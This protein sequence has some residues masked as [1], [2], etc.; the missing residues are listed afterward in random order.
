MQLEVLSEQDLA[1]AVATPASR[2]WRSVFSFPVVMGALLVVLMAFTVRSRF[3]DPDLWWHLKT[4]EIIWN[5]HSIPRVDLF[6]FTAQG[7]PWIAQEWLSQLTIYG[8][9]RLGGY[10]GLMLWLVLLSSL[11]MIGA[12]ALG[13]LY[14][15]SCKL[16]FVAGMV[17]W[18]FSTVGLAIRPHMIGY[19]LLICE[20]L[21]VYLGRWRDRRWFL[22]LPPLFALWINCH[23]SFMFGLVVL[24]IVL[25]CSYFDFGLGL[26][27]G[28][29]WRKEERNM[30][31]AAFALSVAALFVNPIGPKL[32]WYPFDVM[33][34]QPLNVRTISE[35]QQ[36]SFESGRGLA[37]LAIA[38]L[39]LLVPLL[40]RSPLILQELMLAAVGFGFAVRHERMTFVFG[41]LVA[42]ILC[43]LLAGNWDR[44]R[45]EQDS[46]LPNASIVILAFPNS[47]MLAQ[48]VEKANPVEAVNFIKRSGL[49]GRMLN[50]YVYGGY[51]IWAMPEKRVFIDGRADV[52]E[53]AGVLTE[54]TNWDSLHID[55][56][57]FLNKYNIN[58]CLL[59]RQ[60]GLTH[61]LPLLAG[62]KMVYSDEQAA[63][64]ARQA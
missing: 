61:V 12:Y 26:L 17:T 22:A 50:E 64:F 38:G 57:G 46:V 33:L 51:L 19:L 7:H 30:L 6:S 28:D 45:R 25:A 31:A 20:L 56:G 8:A 23:S 48:Q 27:I 42:P 54:Y 63:V 10:T 59:P 16:G 40:R 37:L 1:V 60:S 2:W 53:P 49:S 41:I 24:A 58:F 43:R 5:T 3:S 47:R 13:T 32:I 29:G 62:W 35:W 52:Y 34:N 36:P 55:P 39:I 15:G 14:A 44:Y 9:Y 21:I 18:L 11:L 4:G